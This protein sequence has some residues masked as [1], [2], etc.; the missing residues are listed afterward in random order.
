MW[1]WGSCEIFQDS[2]LSNSLSHIVLRSHPWGEVDG[3]YVA[4]LLYKAGC[5]DEAG[6]AVQQAR[7]RC[8]ACHYQA[9][10]ILL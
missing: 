2:E 7:H 1:M 8:T 5:S 10:G 4:G 9:Q 6:G 3:V